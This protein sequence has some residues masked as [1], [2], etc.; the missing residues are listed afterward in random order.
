M[1]DQFRQIFGVASDPTL[2]TPCALW[3]ILMELR[4]MLL[5]PDVDDDEE[6]QATVTALK[7]SFL[8]Q[9]L[10]AFR[11][12]T[13]TKKEEDDDESGKKFSTKNLRGNTPDTR[14]LWWMLAP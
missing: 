2:K 7:T 4:S 9:M 11:L 14:F 12:A 10:D 6:K 1:I 5:E 3:E 13:K 8:T